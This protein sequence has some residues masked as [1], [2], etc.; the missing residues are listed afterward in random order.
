MGILLEKQILWQVQHYPVFYGTQ[1]S[2]AVLN[3]S[4]SI[5]DGFNTDLSLYVFIYLFT[6]LFN[7]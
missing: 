1:W 6:Y 4:V 2:M 7:Y 3:L 5:L